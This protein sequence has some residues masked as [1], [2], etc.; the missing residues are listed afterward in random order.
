MISD[1]LYLCPSVPHLWQESIEMDSSYKSGANMLNLD[2]S[3][4]QTHRW[5]AIVALA[6]AILR[7]IASSDFLPPWKFLGTL[8]SRFSAEPDWSLTCPTEGSMK[9][10]VNSRYRV[11]ILE[12]RVFL[13]LSGQLFPAQGFSVGESPKSQVSGDFNVDGVLDIAT[14]NSI[15]GTVSLLLGAGNKNFRPAS[16]IPVGA[17]PLSLVTADFDA[18]GALDIATANS[19]DNT[20]SILRGHS[21][22]SFTPQA[23]IAVGSGPSWI[24]AVDLNGDGKTDLATANAGSA[25]ISIALNNGDGTFATATSVVVGTSPS[26]VVAADFNQDGKL[27]LVTTNNNSQGTLSVRLGNGNGTF[28]NTATISVESKPVS[29]VAAD[30]NKDNKP[31]LAYVTNFFGTGSVMFLSGNGN[32]GFVTARLISP[33]YY[34]TAITACDL[35]DDGEIDLAVADQ[36]C[37]ILLGSSDGAFTRQQLTY[38]SF[39]ASSVLTGDLNDD[40]VIDLSFT[41]AGRSSGKVAVFFGTGNAQFHGISAL[42]VS[43][44]RC[45]SVADFNSDGIADLAATEELDNQVAVF[46]GIGG[47]TFASPT[48]IGV[49]AS[50]NCLITPDLNSDGNLDLVVVNGSGFSVSILLGN[51]TGGFSPTVTMP[52][53]AFPTSVAG[54]DFNGDAKIDLAV[55]N[56]NSGTLTLLFGRGDGTFTT[57]GTLP[58]GHPPHSVIAVDLNNDSKIDL[59]TANSTSES[60]LSLLFGNGL[61]SFAPAQSL[62]VG[63]YTENVIAVDVNEDGNVDLIS[64]DSYSPGG[65]AGSTLSLLLGNGHGSFSAAIPVPVGPGPYGVVAG[66]FNDDGRVDLCT[67][68]NARY[69]VSILLGNGDATFTSL[70]EINVGNNPKWVTSGDL[71][72]DG[73]TDLAVASSGVSIL[74]NC[75]EASPPR[76]LSASL[77]VD[78]LV[79]AFRFDAKIDASNLSSLIREVTNLSTGVS[80]SQATEVTLASDA[81][82]V[83]FGV[84]GNWDDGNYRFWIAAGALVGTSGLAT[85]SDV[86]FHTFVLAADAT[87]DRKVDTQDFNLL[88]ANFGGSNK[89][90]SQGNFNYDASG[91]VDSID[92]NILIA[93]FGKKLAPPGG[94]SGPSAAIFAAPDWSPER[95]EV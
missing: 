30:F 70:P 35:N 55:T 87:R 6:G 19:G 74:L 65:T 24:I 59:V 9:K 62:T 60:S 16:S 43:R 28:K 75:G 69:S 83:R 38:S 57:G 39:F 61:G 73:K 63:R 7:R 92:L 25:S 78:S 54:A 84:Q 89:V 49:G 79:A 20:I 36:T 10:P 26:C 8:F 52:V 66:D 91:I 18:D 15:S 93:Q 56:N 46:L 17:T 77:D 71:N 68:N 23:T 33:A 3:I 94:P 45:A 86:E 27:D 90:F 50:P 51:G 48:R 12:A 95:L 13:S 5:I 53:G 2:S 41:A 31:D 58:V 81:R 4:A 21:D 47:G 34:P 76:A 37:S 32:G 40:G 22:A 42:S 67:A 11:E 82:T 29:L 80:V 72:N 44:P 64:A 1:C 14:A 85:T 88:A